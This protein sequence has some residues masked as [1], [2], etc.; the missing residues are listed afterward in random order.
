MNITE[1]RK[2]FIGANEKR[3]KGGGYNIRIIEKN[4]FVFFKFKIRFFCFKM[5]NMIMLGI[6]VS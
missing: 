5:L 4:L 1:K 2:K 3:G 6:F